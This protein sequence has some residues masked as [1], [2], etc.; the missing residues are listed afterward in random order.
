[1]AVAKRTVFAKGPWAP[2]TGRDQ[3]VREQH[4]PRDDWIV[5]PVI[6]TVVWAWDRRDTQV[7]VLVARWAPPAPDWAVSGGGVSA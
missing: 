4:P 6:V 1:V 3:S 5:S 7:A 2:T